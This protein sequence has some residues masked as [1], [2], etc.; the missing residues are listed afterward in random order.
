MLGGFWLRKYVWVWVY[1][2]KYG[3]QFKAEITIAL[4]KE[5][6]INSEERFYIEMLEESIICDTPEEV[7]KTFKEIKNERIFKR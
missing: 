2:Y 1:T 5:E 4:E 7:I 6:E 3:E